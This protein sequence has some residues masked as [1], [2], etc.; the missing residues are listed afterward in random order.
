MAVA[1]VPVRET[2][3]AILRQLNKADVENTPDSPEQSL[4]LVEL[5]RR[6]ADFPAL[7]TGEVRLPVALGLLLTNGYVAA[8]Q[9]QE[10]SWGRGRN[11]ERRYRITPEG[12]QFLVEN[13]VESD[14]V[15]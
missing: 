5:E 8:A 15:K 11:V 9:D 7:L 3:F 6:L 2:F 13:L 12:K 14:R 1:N 4:E 10:Y